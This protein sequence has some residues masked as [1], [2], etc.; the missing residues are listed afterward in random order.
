MLFILKKGLGILMIEK[1]H[2]ICYK[3]KS[4]SNRARCI[5]G[6]SLVIIVMTLIFF[7][8]LFKGYIDGEFRSIESLQAYISKFGSLGII[9]LIL[10]QAT[11]VV[12]PILPGF[13]GC[14]VGSILFGP[15]IGFCCNYIGISGG[16][17]I[18]FFLARKYGKSLLE[19]IFPK[20]KYSKWTN[21]TSKSKSYTIFLFLAMVLPLFPD[22]YLCYLTGLSKMNA[23]KFIWIIILGK[24]WCILA[25]SLGFSLI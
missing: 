8:M 24:P 19:D 9:F 16:S 2:N 3:E 17:I 18:A 23:R 6:I 21:W 10:F 13:L 1:K 5:R 20:E 7:T 15:L 14:A 22:D 25:Y 4:I 12:I 11:Q